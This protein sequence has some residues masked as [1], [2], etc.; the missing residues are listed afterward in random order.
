MPNRSPMPRREPPSFTDHVLTHPFESAMAWLWMILGGL[1][2]VAALTPLPVSESLSRLPVPLAL[3][4]SVALGA[5]GTLT[6]TGVA[7]PG[8]RV[9][10][11]WAI[12]RPGL[13]LGA[14][15][16]AAYLAVVL[17]ARSFPVITVSLCIA[18]VCGA[19]LR[20]IASRR[21]EKDT[22]RALSEARVI[23]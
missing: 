17:W 11:A 21:L 10:T 18:M 22:R 19:A 15:G 23:P 9:T 2:L 5:G 20:L 12:E 7:W 4:L 1:L 6:M 8:T 16:W 3:A 13:I 14:A